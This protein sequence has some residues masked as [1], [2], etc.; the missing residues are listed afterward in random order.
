MRYI[1]LIK[2]EFFNKAYNIISSNDFSDYNSSILAHQSFFYYDKI[3]NY[4]L[5]FM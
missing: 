3:M 4:F 1:V 5:I 2:A